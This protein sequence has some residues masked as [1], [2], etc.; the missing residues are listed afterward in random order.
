MS[1][2]RKTLPPKGS[3]D[4]QIVELF[5]EKQPASVLYEDNGVTRANG[6]I[7]AIF[8]KEGEKW[9]RLMDA[10]EIRIGSL[11]AVNGTFASDYS[12]C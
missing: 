8:E 7:A 11:I 9:F 3:F 12:E 4:S 6:L 10:T 2:T 1:D 5:E